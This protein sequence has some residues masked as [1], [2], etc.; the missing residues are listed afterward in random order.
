MASPIAGSPLNRNIGCG[1][2]AYPFFIVATSARRKNLPS[3]NRLMRFRSSTELNAPETRIAAPVNQQ[4][5][6][7]TTSRSSLERFSGSPEPPFPRAENGDG[8][9]KT[10]GTLHGDFRH[11][12]DIEDMPHA[13]TA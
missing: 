8:T 7:T 4:K 3:A 13:I 9:G 5:K 12:R 2:S 6:A 10:D 1:G 11:L